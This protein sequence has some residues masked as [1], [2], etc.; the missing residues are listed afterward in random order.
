MNLSLTEWIDAFVKWMLHGFKI[1]FQDEFNDTIN[2][3]K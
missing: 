1:K 3:K 2:S